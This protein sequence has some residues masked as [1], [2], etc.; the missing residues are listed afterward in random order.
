MEPEILNTDFGNSIKKVINVTNDID[1]FAMQIKMCYYIVLAYYYYKGDPDGSN[2]YGYVGG[3]AYDLLVNLSFCLGSENDLG[4][5]KYF[6]DITTWIGHMYG[7]IQR[8]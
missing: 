3:V 8:G 7:A 6:L 5:S 1:I 2:Y 4:K